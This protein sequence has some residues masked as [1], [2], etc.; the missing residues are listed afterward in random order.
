MDE[1]GRRHLQ[2][3]DRFIASLTPEQR[4]LARVNALRDNQC[5]PYQQSLAEE[6]SRTT[7]EGMTPAQAMEWTRQLTVEENKERFQEGFQRGWRDADKQANN[8][9]WIGLAV[10][11]CI[12]IL[13][14]LARC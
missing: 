4:A 12:A 11:C 5:T 2:A 8:L 6:M 7:P 3:V 9:W 10:G 13:I 1:L 14:L